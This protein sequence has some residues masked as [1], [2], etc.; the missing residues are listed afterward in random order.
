MIR[1]KIEGMTCNHCVQHVRE[2]LAAVA[3]VE[4]VRVQLQPG[5]AEVEGNVAAEALVAVVEAEG[6]GAEPLANPAH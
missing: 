5:Q 2:A 6:Y 1:L 4:A 3:G